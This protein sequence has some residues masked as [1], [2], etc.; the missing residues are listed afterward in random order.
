LNGIQIFGGVFVFTLGGVFTPTFLA[1]ERA[2]SMQEVCD[3]ARFQGLVQIAHC[4]AAIEFGMTPHITGA[5][6]AF[7]RHTEAPPIEFAVEGPDFGVFVCSEG[8]NIE[9]VCLVN[10]ST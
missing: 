5:V 2:A 6:R 1:P 4:S 9:Q 3:L 7:S 10:S 8:G